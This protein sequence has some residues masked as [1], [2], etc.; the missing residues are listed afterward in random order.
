MATWVSR[1]SD[2]AWMVR[3]FGD[4]ELVLS[5]PSSYTAVDVPGEG[6]PNPRT[7]LYDPA[8]PTKRRPATAA[9]V[10]AYDEA[11]A[12]A[13]ALTARA[14]KDRLA[15]FATVAEAYNASWATMTNAQK[16]TEV[17]RLAKRWEQ[18]RN[19]LTRN[20]EFISW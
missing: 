15:T 6:C 7:E 17:V 2:S 11:M 14:D 3:G 9:E 1:N 19:W 13:A 12:D 5:Q 8:S 4:P 20:Y 18:H 10:T 16:R